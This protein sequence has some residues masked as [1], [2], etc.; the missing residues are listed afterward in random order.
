M[1]S[2]AKHPSIF[3][4]SKYRDSSS[5]SAPQNDNRPMCHSL[6][7]RDTR[8]GPNKPLL[9]ERVARRI[10]PEIA[11]RRQVGLRT[12]GAAGGTPRRSHLLNPDYVHNDTVRLEQWLEQLRQERKLAEHEAE[13]AA[14]SHQ[15]SERLSAAARVEVRRGL[16][17]VARAEVERLS[18]Q[19]RDL[20]RLVE[21]V[22]A[23]Y[24][25]LERQRFEDAVDAAG[26]VCDWEIVLE[27]CA[28]AGAAGTAFE[29]EKVLAQVPLQARVHY[30]RAVST[31]LF[32]GFTVCTLLDPPDCRHQES[33]KATAHYLFGTI[34]SSNEDE[35]AAIFQVAQW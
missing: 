2:A 29:D 32:E 26:L 35:G 8:G 1:L 15:H 7:M 22:G 11:N 4:P 23:A 34:P 9:S 14:D 31:R 30:E 18:S 28:N 27:R 10:H 3:K 33:P 17:S 13:R 5:P 12:G 16:I 19:I 25:Y 6:R 21:R 20:E 24:P